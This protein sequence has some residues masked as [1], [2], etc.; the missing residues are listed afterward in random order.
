MSGP[1]PIEA[2]RLLGVLPEFKVGSAQSK[3]HITPLYGG[4]LNL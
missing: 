3:S 4:S 2:P 1:N